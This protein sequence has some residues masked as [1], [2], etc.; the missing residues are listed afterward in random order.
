MFCLLVYFMQVFEKDFLIKLSRLL[1]VTISLYL[2]GD[3]TR[4]L[5]IL[6]E[7]EFTRYT[8][9]FKGVSFL[10]LTVFFIRHYNEYLK[11]SKL[12]YIGVLTVILICIF[13]FNQLVFKTYVYENYNLLENFLYLIRYLS[14]PILLIVFYPLFVTNFLKNSLHF[15]FYTSFF[16]INCLIV[17]LG[18]LFEIKLF[19]TYNSRFG[20]M[21]IFN[22]SN[23][24]SFIFILYITYF[25]TCLKNYKSYFLILGI[26]LISFLVGTKKIYLFS[27]LLFLYFIYEKRVYTKKTFYLILVS[28][29]SLFYIFFDRIKELLFSVFDVIF[30]V[31]E[32]NGLIT[33]I[34]SL[35]DQLLINSFDLNYR[36]WSFLNYFF[37]GPFFPNNSVELEWIDLY[38]FFGICGIPYFVN[39]FNLYLKDIS[40]KKFKILFLFILTVSF[41]SGGFILEANTSLVFFIIIC[42]IKLNLFNNSNN[43]EKL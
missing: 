9:L 43:F 25:Y 2:L 39:L 15:E 8:A 32:K 42:K 12:R 27:W 35:R 22:T 26:I 19:G 33:A 10:L 37:G 5:S 4:K 24:A 38:Y 30:S 29:L 3:I 28:L 18:V 23:Q 36:G 7:L 1:T 14:W 11:S 31:F 20:S 40:F 41:F 34:F 17:V 13:I 6:F 16:F 21:G